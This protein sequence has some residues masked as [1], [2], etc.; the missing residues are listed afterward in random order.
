M[1]SE[2]QPTPGS[3][4][5][6]PD[7]AAVDAANLKAIVLM[8]ASMALFAV[9]D[10]FIKLASSHV[11]VGEIMTIQCIVGVTYFGILA[12]RNGS[13]ISREALLST[14][15]ILRNIGEVVGAMSFVT[16]LSL[17][18]ISNASAILQAAP[19]A[20]TLGAALFL[21]EPVG[22]RRW[23][24]IGLGF[25]GVVI[26]VR[27][28]MAGFNG[29]SLFA[30][31]AVFGLAVRDLGTRAAPKGIPT[32]IIALVASLTVMVSAAIYHTVASEWQLIPW[33]V[34][35]MILTA[36]VIGNAGFHCVVIALRMGEISVVAPFRYTRIVVAMI[37]GLLVF[38]ER[39]DLLTYVGSALIVA[40]GIYTLYR[41]QIVNR[42]MRRTP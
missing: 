22:W 2:S 28:G 42:R 6:L 39:P 36:A 1:S 14:P 18:P 40:S 16:A 20:V 24:A 9:D 29:A 27:P 8:T 23:M 11:G 35:A 37:I 7:W 31:A 32:E 19:L 17:M 5:A 15:M 25:A 3:P 26:I 13:R 12:A 10:M 30:V 41:E 21:R 4:G 34:F 33:R 38:G